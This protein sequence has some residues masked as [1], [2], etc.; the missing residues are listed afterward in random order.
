MKLNILCAGCST[1][2]E[3][4]SVAMTLLEGLRY[5]KAW[6]LRIFAGDLSERCISTAQAGSY[7]EEQLKGIPFSYRKKYLSATDEGA[8]FGDEVKNLIRFSRLNLK[9]LMEGGDFPG[10]GADFAGFDL[11]FCRN[12]MIYFSAAD[13]QKLINTLYRFLLPG[14]YLFTGDAEPLH[15]FE[16]NYEAV[17]GADCLIYQKMEMRNDVKTV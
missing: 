15:L 5:P 9:D 12:V 6:D 10:C 17:R 2:E 7:S 3:P 13:Q 16:H 4:Y 8:V 11:V 1:G 14:G